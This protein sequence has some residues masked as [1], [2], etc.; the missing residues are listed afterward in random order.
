MTR[1]GEYGLSLFLSVWG[2]IMETWIT[3]NDSKGEAIII[4]TYFYLLVYSLN[5]ESSK[6]ALSWDYWPKHLHDSTSCAG[7]FLKDAILRIL[8]PYIATQG[9]LSDCGNKVEGE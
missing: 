8:R 6:I 3:K 9:L 7:D 2:F 4:L 5:L 1:H